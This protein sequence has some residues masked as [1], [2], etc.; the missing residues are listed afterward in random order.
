MKSNVKITIIGLIGASSLSAAGW[1]IGSVSATQSDV[2]VIKAVAPL[3]AQNTKEIKDDVA[4]LKI[5]V[6]KLVTGQK[7]I[8]DKLGIKE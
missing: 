4:T 6:G 2:T 7:R 8:E 1:W 3:I 5:E